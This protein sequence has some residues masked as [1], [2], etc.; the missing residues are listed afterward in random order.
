MPNPLAR[1]TPAEWF[2]AIIAALVMMI[3]MANAVERSVNPTTESA[4]DYFVATDGN[5]TN[6]GTETAPFATLAKAREAVRKRVATGLEKNILVLIR[7]GT[8]LQTE[9]LTFGLEDSGT[10]KFSITYAASPNELVVLSGGRRIEGWKKGNDE[11]WTVVLPETSAREWYFRQLFI[12]G[13]RGVRARTPNRDSTE[14]WCRMLSSTAKY[15]DEETPITVKLGGYKQ[16][17]RIQAYKNPGDVELVYI[18]NNDEG[19]TRIGTIDEAAQ[20][21]TLAPPHRWNSKAHPNDWYLSFPDPHWK[22]CYLENAIEMLDEPGEWYLDRRTGVLSYWPRAGEDLT[23]SQVIAPLVQKTL[24]AIV[25]TRERPIMNLHFKAIHLEYLD[26]PLPDIGYMGLFCCTVDSGPKEKPEH[27]FIDAALEYEYARKCKFI[28]GGITHVGA[29]GICPRRGTAG[30][31][32]EGNEI[33]DLGAGG[34]GVSEIRQSP[35]GDRPWNPFPREEDYV[36]YRIANNHI[37]DCG[38]D[39]Y[40]AVGI[41]LFMTR[42]SIVAHNLI[43]DT[44]YSGIQWAGDSNANR[45]STR[46]NAVEFNHIYNAMKVTADGAGMYITYA[47]AGATVI[48]GNLIHDTFCNPFHRGLSEVGQGDVP[49][50]GLY[51]DGNMSGGRYENNVVFR[52]SGGPVFFLAR[53]ENSIWIDNLFQKNGAPPEEFFEVMV[54]A[55]GLEPAYQKSILNEEPNPCRISS[56]SNAISGKACGARQFDLLAKGRG[57]VEIFRAPG[58]VESDLTL[59]LHDLNPAARYVLLA[60]SGALAPPEKDYY[61]PYK[62]DGNDVSALGTLPILS[63]VEALPLSDIGLPLADGKAGITGAELIKKGISLKLGKTPR[64]IWIAYHKSG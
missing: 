55:A 12:N 27:G 4:A 38:T 33:A 25:G 5:D 24:L 62:L 53:H 54:A 63:A 45:K 61:A 28:D 32:I 52:N 40:G 46:D 42:G 51:L 47:H 48:C 22:A 2:A 1:Y 60:Y 64:A 18:N 57:V 6:P 17:F 20:T 15:E 36:G 11:I 14:P 30:I 43:H 58:A 9:T 31:V 3:A 26:W 7:G 10:E 29:M 8:Y 37:H 44:A 34:I 41:T 16:P 13:Q 59:T 56:L 19:R 35:I 23:H 49:C 50:F 39:Y 21:F